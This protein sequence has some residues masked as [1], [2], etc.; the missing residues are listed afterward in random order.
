MTISNKVLIEFNNKELNAIRIIDDMLEDLQ[1]KF[2]EETTLVSVT[3]GEA[4]ELNE[5]WR[6]RGI[7]SSLV[8][9]AYW[10]V[11]PANNNDQIICF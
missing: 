7:L 10:D 6:M 11:N 4:I 8:S 5:I 9:N 1:L 2:S 3:T